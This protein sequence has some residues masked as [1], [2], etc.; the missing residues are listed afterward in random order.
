MKRPV[1]RH[2]GIAVAAQN[3][4]IALT[5]LRNLPRPSTHK[6]TIAANAHRTARPLTEQP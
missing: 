3:A 4:D 6:T 5:A 1:T 2:M